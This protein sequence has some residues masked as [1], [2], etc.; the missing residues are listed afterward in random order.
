[1]K[2]IISL[3]L[4]SVLLLGCVFTLASC[5]NVSASYSKKINKAAESG[6]CITYEQVKED[7]GED[8]VDITLL[9]SGAI[10]AVKGCR[11][12]SDIEE[13]IKSGKTVKGIVITVAFGNATKAEYKEITNSDLK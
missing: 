6:D 5:S 11:S 4:A 7:L 13:K 9:K 8:A 2:R 1:M 10:I 3:I 12:I